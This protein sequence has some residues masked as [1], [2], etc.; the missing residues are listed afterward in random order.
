MSDKNKEGLE[1][2]KRLVH[3]LNVH[4]E[5]QGNT[6]EL[7]YYVPI[8]EKISIKKLDEWRNIFRNEPPISPYDEIKRKNEQLQ[9]M[10]LKLQESEYHYRMLTDTLPLMMF[11]LDEEG[12]FIYAN[13]WLLDYLGYTLENLNS[14]EQLNNIHEDDLPSSENIRT[15]IRMG[16]AIKTEW[17][18]KEKKNGKI[19]MA[20]CFYSAVKKWIRYT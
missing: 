8:E 2:A 7:Y 3:K 20:S 12:K 14:R 11:T 10:A 17:R 18:V 4:S 15:M 9:Q 1:Y 5:E 19:F 6:I 13:K 16:K